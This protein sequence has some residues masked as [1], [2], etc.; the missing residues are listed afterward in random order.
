MYSF[1]QNTEEKSVWMRIHQA[2][3]AP[4]C[5]SSLF[6]VSSNASM[7]QSHTTDSRTA[8][9]LSL[10]LKTVCSLFQGKQ[11]SPMAVIIIIKAFSHLCWESPYFKLQL[12]KMVVKLRLS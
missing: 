3:I 7:Q 2:A 1:H 12:F 11:I 4:F 6:L 8:C 5:S 9:T 10:V